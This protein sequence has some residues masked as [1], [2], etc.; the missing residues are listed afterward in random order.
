ME[1]V[2]IEAQM[3]RHPVRG[4]SIVKAERGS[5]FLLGLGNAKLT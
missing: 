2:E 1:G 4:K 3:D 5:P